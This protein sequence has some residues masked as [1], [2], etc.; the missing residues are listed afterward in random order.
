MWQRRRRYLLLRAPLVADL[1]RFDH[2][3]SLPVPP[4]WVLAILWDELARRDL[5]ESLTDWTLERMGRDPSVGPFQITGATAASVVQFAPWGRPY[6]ALSMADNRTL[7]WDFGH[8]A[9]VAA[10]RLRQILHHWREFEPWRN[11]GLGRDRVRPLALLGTLY[12]QGLGVPKA[13]PQANGRGAQIAAFGEQIRELL[14]DLTDASRPEA[15]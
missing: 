1:C 10:G 13:H 6:R 11:E 3:P 7:L 2:Q 5:T 14:P 12:S 15:S 8:A 4:A 9:R